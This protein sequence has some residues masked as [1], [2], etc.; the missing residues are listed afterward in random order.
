M[1]WL[2]YLMRQFY[3]YFN[4]LHL[5]KQ[6]L[7]ENYHPCITY[8]IIANNKELKYLLVYSAIRSE[9]FT[10]LPWKNLK[11]QIDS[12]KKQNYMLP[13]IYMILILLMHIS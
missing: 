13:P 1:M 5:L 8:N 11:D 7:S 12:K 10:H 6:P 2:V 9:K 4:C 3:T